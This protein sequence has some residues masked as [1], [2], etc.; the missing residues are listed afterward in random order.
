MWYTCDYIKLD[1]IARSCR[2]CRDTINPK[3]YEL[4]A[5]MIFKVLTDTDYKNELIEKGISRMKS[6]NWKDSAKKTQ[7][8][9]DLFI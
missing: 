8:I 9:Y 5:D 1:I 4:M 7:E 2:G 6:F 3:Y